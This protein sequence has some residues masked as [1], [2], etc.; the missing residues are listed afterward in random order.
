[1]PTIGLLSTIA[2]VDPKNCAS[3]NAKMPPSEATSQYPSPSGVGAMPTIGLLSA[4]PP[5]EPQNCA[6]PKE[7]T[8]PSEA[9]SQYPPCGSAA[10]LTMGFVRGTSRVSPS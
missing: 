8:P 4:I 1:M 3:P 6:A 2:P 9:T 10:P 5:V 7:K